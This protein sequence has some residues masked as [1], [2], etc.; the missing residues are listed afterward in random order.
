MLFIH[1][2][3]RYAILS[4]NLTIAREIA[5]HP[6]FYGTLPANPFS[7]CTAGGGFGFDAGDGEEVLDGAEEAAVAVLPV[8]P[9]GG[10]R[11]WSVG[12]GEFAVG[13]D[14]EFG[15]GEVGCWDECWKGL[16]RQVAKSPRSPREEILTTDC[17]EG[18]AEKREGGLMI[19]EVGFW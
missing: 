14:A 8:F 10:D 6:S 7:S 1:L 5:F 4:R 3:G 16:N 17:T 9:E 2:H 19:V 13:V 11:F 18:A 15:V 12:F